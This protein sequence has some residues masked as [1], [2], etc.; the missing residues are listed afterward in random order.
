MR[1][2]RARV[3][4][5]QEH[6]RGTKSLPIMQKPLLEQAPKIQDQEASVISLIFRFAFFAGSFLPAFAASKAKR[7][8]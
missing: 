4:A 7:A 8:M 2:M 1:Q 6:G 5:A 3:G